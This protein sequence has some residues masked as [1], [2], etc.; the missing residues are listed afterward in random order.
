MSSLPRN[1]GWPPKYTVAASVETRVLVLRLLNNIAMVL[2]VRAPNRFSGVVPDLRAAFARAA[3]LTSEVSSADV[4][5]AMD[6]K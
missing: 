3:P 5:S 4:T 6:R 1:I 2:P